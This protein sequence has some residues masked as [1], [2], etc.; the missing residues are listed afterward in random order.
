MIQVEHSAGILPSL[1]KR[2][3]L[4]RTKEPKRKHAYEKYVKKEDVNGL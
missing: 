1:F 4:W 2:T 3:E